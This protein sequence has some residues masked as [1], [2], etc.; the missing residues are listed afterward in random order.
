MAVLECSICSCTWC[1]VLSVAEMVCSPN[2]D[3]PYSPDALSSKLETKH[4]SLTTPL[5]Q[6]REPHEIGKGEILLFHRH[7]SISQLPQ[8]LGWGHVT[9]FGQ[10]AVS[11]IDCVSSGFRRVVRVVHSLTTVERVGESRPLSLL[12][13]WGPGSQPLGGHVIKP[14]RPG[15]LVTGKSATLERQLTLIKNCMSKK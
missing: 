14:G 3:I 12:P 15:S 2:T 6:T 1:M 11:G 8:W 5:S 7:P 9:R 4:S 13:L 10:R